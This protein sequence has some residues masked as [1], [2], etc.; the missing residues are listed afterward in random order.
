MTAWSD[1]GPTVLVPQTGYLANARNGWTVVALTLASGA[2]RLT[3][4]EPSGAIAWTRDETSVTVFGVA[5]DE[6]GRVRQAARP[7]SPPSS[8]QSVVA[9]GP[10]GAV[11]WR[12]ES[13]FISLAEWAV[14]TRLDPFGNSI[15]LG[16]GMADGLPVLRVLKYDKAGAVAWSRSAFPG[17]S[18]AG[19]AVGP[20]GESVVAAQDDPFDPTPVLSVAKFD[21]AGNEVW[22]RSYPVALALIGNATAVAV[23]SGG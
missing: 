6:S 18:P 17:H 4:Y 11:E 5:I 14:A 2:A 20:S 13:P 1:Y 16:T 3:V 10:S 8:A 9:H 7:T 21:A 23:S 19:L 12:G 22:T 15:V